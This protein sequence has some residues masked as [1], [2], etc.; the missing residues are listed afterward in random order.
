M[1]VDDPGTER[2]SR[3]I[4]GDLDREETAEVDGRPRARRGARGASSTASSGFAPR[5]SRWRDREH[6]PERLDASGGPA[7]SGDR[8]RQRSAPVGAPAGL[9]CGGCSRGL[10]SSSRSNDSNRPGDPQLAGARPRG[11][12]SR[13]EPNGSPSRRCRTSPTGRRASPR[14]PPTACSPPRNRR[15]RPGDGPGSGSRGDGAP[16]LRHDRRNRRSIPKRSR[17]R[18]FTP[19]RI[20]RR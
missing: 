18:S 11:R 2:L 9:R 20:T 13:A 5:C 15:S 8:S 6:P 12:R 14:A 7:A 16:V 3:L 10:R 17:G 19:T 4:D 1:V